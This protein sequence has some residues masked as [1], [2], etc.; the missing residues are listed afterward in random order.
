VRVSARLDSDVLRVDVTSEPG[1][2]VVRVVLP[3]FHFMGG[4]S[5]DLKV[6]VPRGS[7]VNVSSVSAGVDVT[8]VQ[9]DQH[10]RSVSG[11]ISSNIEGDVAEVKTVSGDVRLKGSGKPGRLHVDT[12]SGDLHLE[13]A[14][15]DVEAG[16]VSGSIEAHLDQVHSVRART[17]AGS[18]RFE[19][20]LLSGASLDAQTLSGQLR[21]R[22]HA[23]DGYQY[24]VSTFSGHIDDC[25][26]VA[27]E[28]T[29]RYGSGE[30]LQGTLGQGSAHVFIKSLSGTVDLCDR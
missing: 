17:T 18:V 14:A 7:R 30:R 26:N 6:Q 3:G 2:T 24:E 4:G 29:S 25:F 20:T 16:T 1:R 21:V 28:R 19:G 10:L 27:P 23:S 11:A 5:A 15:G 9:G 13:H 22:A 8:G 12:V